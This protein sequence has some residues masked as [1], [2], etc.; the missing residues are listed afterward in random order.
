MHVHRALRPAGRAARVRDEERMLGVDRPRRRTARR[1]RG[2]VSSAS[3]RSRP[4]VIGTS[5][6][7]MRG[8]TT[9]VST[10][11]TAATAASAVSFIGSELA[12]PHGAVGGDERLGV[13]VL[14]PDRDRVGAVAGEDRQEDRTELRDG[15][16]RGDRLGDHR[17]EDP[18]RVALADAARREP[19]RDAV[20]ERAQLAVGQRARSCLLRPP[21]RPRAGRASRRG[22]PTCRRSRARRSASRS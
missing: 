2:A 14:E 13:A 19:V 6:R 22:R 8:T 18:D 4:A 3:V 9:T 5:S 7:P 20:G 16:H 11:G 12:A 1:A 15:H 17:E 21:R 10:D